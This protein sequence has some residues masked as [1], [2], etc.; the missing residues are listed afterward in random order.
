MSCFSN[1]LLNNNK[2]MHTENIDLNFIK[3]WLLT[4]NKNKLFSFVI[5]GSK[6]SKTVLVLGSLA[7]YTHMTGYI[8]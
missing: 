5:L 4:E 6:H 1:F 2:K 7:F 8:V 3:W